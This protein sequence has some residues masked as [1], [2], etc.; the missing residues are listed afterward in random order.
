MTDQRVKFSG[1]FKLFIVKL[2]LYFCT[3]DPPMHSSQ[4]SGL[5]MGGLCHGVSGSGLTQLTISQQL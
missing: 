1:V 3:C 4:Y 5:E 2:H